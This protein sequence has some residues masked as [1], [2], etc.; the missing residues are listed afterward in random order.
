MMK[1][2][3][4]L[5][6]LQICPFEH[7]NLND[8]PCLRPMR[9]DYPYRLCILDKN[10]SIAIDVNTKYA[11]DFIEMSTIHFYGMSYKKIQGENRYAILKLSAGSMCEVD[12]DI[13]I[14]AQDIRKQLEMG[15]EF[16]NGNVIDNETYLNLI[17][18][19]M[20]YKKIKSRRK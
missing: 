7:L 16:E 8:S 17:N 18:H 3:Y 12:N 19:E 20:T 5:C 15:K 1:E 10:N 2:R 14:K 13:L 6:E 11:Y 9:N 4:E